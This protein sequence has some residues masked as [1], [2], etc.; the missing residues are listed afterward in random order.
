MMR[1]RHVILILKPSKQPDDEN[2]YHPISLLEIPYKIIAGVMAN[3]LRYAA[4]RIIS[5]SQKG[6]MT[7]RSSADITRSVQDVRDFAQI[8][9]KPLAILGLDFSKAFDSIS[10]A[11][12]KKILKFLKFPDKFIN[13]IMLLLAEAQ[14]ILDINGLRADPFQLIDGTGQGDPI[15][16]F[17]F[18]MVVQIFIC[19]IIHNKDI[20]HFQIG[21]T[22]IIPEM[23]AD[24]IHLFLQGNHEQS[25]F[26]VM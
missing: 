11:G 7:G 3:R 5:P 19:K 6:Y 2:S 18:N 4:D 24:D 26:K 17:L 9:N 16:S 10:H 15:S 8:E 21:N 22:I 23:F 20:K 25:L 14:I 12:L 13:I 1:M